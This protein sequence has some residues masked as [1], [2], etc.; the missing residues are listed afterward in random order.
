[1]DLKVNTGVKDP[2]TKWQ[3]RLKNEKRASQ[4]FE[5]TFRLQIA[6]R[7]DG[8]FVGLLKMRN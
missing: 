3:M 1:V 5:K 2:C 8:S 4:I 6:K 7:E